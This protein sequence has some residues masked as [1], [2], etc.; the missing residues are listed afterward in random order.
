MAISY[1]AICF[2]L[3]QNTHDIKLLKRSFFNEV[4]SLQSHCLAHA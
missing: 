2:D 4:Y 1:S 3:V